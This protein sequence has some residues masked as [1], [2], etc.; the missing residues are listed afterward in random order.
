[1]I[2]DSAQDSIL[3]WDIIDRDFSHLNFSLT[4]VD[5]ISASVFWAVLPK[6]TNLTKLIKIKK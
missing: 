2:K 1:M 5:S 6:L 4:I 3:D